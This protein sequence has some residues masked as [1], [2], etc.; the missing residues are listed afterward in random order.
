MEKQGAVMRN[1]FLSYMDVTPGG[2]TSTF[3]LIGEGFN[4]LTESLNP[5]TKESTYIHQKNKSTSVT[6][7]APEFAFTAENFVGDPVAEYVAMV[8]RDRLTGS[9]AETDIV[10]V[11]CFEQGKTAGSYR[12]DTQH[13]AI[14]V[15]QV[16]GGPGVE[17]MPLTGSFLYKGDPVKGS[18][19]PK[20]STFTPDTVAQETFEV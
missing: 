16:N 1:E 17:S 13:I 18:W 12:A 20:T 6:G 11:C 19:D 7:Y 8:G 2:Q 3:E 5:V 15:D 9:L 14:K 10:N 4:E